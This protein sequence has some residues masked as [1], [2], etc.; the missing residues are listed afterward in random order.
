MIPTPTLPPLIALSRPISDSS[1]R[2]FGS[3][4]C[5]CADALALSRRASTASTLGARWIELEREVIR[6]PSAKGEAGAVAAA[7]QKM[8]RRDGHGEGTSRQGPDVG[9]LPA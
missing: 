1:R 8:R 3:A 6:T 2:R 5:D 9:I 7:A 4:A